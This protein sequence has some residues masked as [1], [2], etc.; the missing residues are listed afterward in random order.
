MH[1]PD[2]TTCGDNNFVTMKTLAITLPAELIERF[3]A[4]PLA[5]R[6]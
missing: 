1:V 5:A 2:Q 6:Q 3:I 4:E